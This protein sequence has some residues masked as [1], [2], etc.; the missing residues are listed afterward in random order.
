LCDVSP[1]LEQHTSSCLRPPPSCAYDDEWLA[2]APPENRLA[3]F[4][5]VGELAYPEGPPN[6]QPIAFWPAEPG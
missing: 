3:E 6:D 5:R 1:S 4:I 2:L